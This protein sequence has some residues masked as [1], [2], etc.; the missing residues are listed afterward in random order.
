MF[1]VR[2]GSQAF[3]VNEPKTTCTCRMWQ[4][5][6]IPCVHATKVILYIN[7]TPESYVPPMFKVCTQLFYP[8]NLEKCL[9]GL[10]RKE[11]DQVVRG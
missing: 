10:E 9:V 2:S 5:S 11:L 7:K 1:E 6:G 3:T 4:L 8:L